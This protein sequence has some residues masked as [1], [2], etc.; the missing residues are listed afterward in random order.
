M[1]TLAFKPERQMWSKKF[2]YDY[3]MESTGVPIH[4]DFFV[5]DLRTVELGWWEERQCLAAFIQLMGSEGVSSSRVTEI[6]ASE[7]NYGKFT[8]EAVVAFKTD[9]R[10]F[11]RGTASNGGNWRRGSGS[12]AARGSRDGWPSGCR[13]ADGCASS[14]GA[15][16]SRS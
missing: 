6:P 14:G 10:I 3:W 1:A 5:D 7:T 2:T 8:T 4:K 16:W 9:R 13:S 12:A 15:T 11:T